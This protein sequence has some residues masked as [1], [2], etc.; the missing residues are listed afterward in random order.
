MTPR[1]A[2]SLGRTART[3]SRLAA[4]IGLVAAA[5][6]ALA[7]VSAAFAQDDAAPIPLLS[8]TEM[9]E[10][11]HADADPIVA[12]M[13]RPDDLQLNAMHRLAVVRLA[14]ADDVREQ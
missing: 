12:G 8:D 1:A 4:T 11:L 13:E 5:G 6:L 2:N 10:I 7:P 14:D 9:N 3:K